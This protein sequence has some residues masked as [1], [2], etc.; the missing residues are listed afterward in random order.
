VELAK[1]SF[2]LCQD[3]SRPI[4]RFV[5]NRF[6][7]FLRLVEKNISREKFM[8]IVNSSAAELELLGD[9]EGE[10]EK[11]EEGEAEGEGQKEGK[12]EEKTVKKV[13][14]LIPVTIPSTGKTSLLEIIEKRQ[15]EFRLWSVSNDEIRRKVMDDLRKKKKTMTRE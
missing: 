1:R 5:S 11:L 4:S 8:E 3:Q 7:D 9:E 14:V 12:K 13:I 2:E 10:K 15:S 6:I